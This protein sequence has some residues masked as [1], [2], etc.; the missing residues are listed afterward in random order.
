MNGLTPDLDR[1]P[2]AATRLWRN[3]RLVTLSPDRAGIGSVE[4]GAVA[5]RDGRIV[6]A[7]PESEMGRDDTFIRQLIGNLSHPT[8]LKTK[9]EGQ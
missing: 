3:A 8:P 2:E 6:Y 7:G 1:G 5:V 4:R 9:Q